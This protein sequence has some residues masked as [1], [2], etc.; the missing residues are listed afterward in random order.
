LPAGVELL[1]FPQDFSPCIQRAYRLI[2]PDFIV[3]MESELWPNHIWAAGDR[4]LP[5]FLVNARLSPRSARRYRQLRWAARLV[6]RHLTLI[7]AQ[8]RDDAANFAALATPD[9][10]V[11][12]GNM[13][14]DASLPHKTGAQL[15]P[16][17]LR[18][19]LGLTSHQPVLL[20]GSTHPG[21]EEI[22]F[23]IYQNLRR[24]LPK[25]FLVIVPRHVERT[26]EIVEMAL[27]RQVSCLLRADM[28]S[29]LKP[30]SG[31]YDCLLVNTTGELKWLYGIATVIFVGKSLIGQGGQ[32]IIEAAASG[33]PVVFGPHM[34]NF[35]EIA[36]QF[37]EGGGC[38]QVNDAVGLQR[39]CADLL[40]HEARRDEI[41]AAARS[42][43]DANLGATRRTVDLIAGMV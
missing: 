42:I 25:L 10:V 35:S 27:H 41:T 26:P 4:H 36:R 18:E 8:S 7:C 29:A 9:R 15:D 40:Q 31:Q 24:E 13:K 22:L 38:V 14:F 21:E 17:A 34:Q 30:G 3:L 32:N 12:T 16:A 28:K 20:G 33:H 2:Q 39:A 23:E 6:F 37:V 19:E 1:Y 43:I 11:F 5:V